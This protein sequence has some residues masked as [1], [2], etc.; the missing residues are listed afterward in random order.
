M[1]SGAGIWHKR[2]VSPTAVPLAILVGGLLFTLAIASVVMA[3]GRERDE[4]RFERAVLGT[5]DLI[6]RRLDLYLV[7]LRGTA[8]LFA[9]LDT[10]RPED[11]RAYVARLDV[12]HHYPGIQG[13]GWTQRLEAGLDEEGEFTER[14]AIR[15]LEPLDARNQA[16]LGYD[17]YSEP[18]RRAAMSQARDRATAALSGR[19]RLVQEIY[20][21]EQPGFLLYVPV[22]RGGEPPA[23]LEQRRASLLGFVYSPFRARDLFEGI[24]GF[25]P[26]PR[27]SFRVYDGPMADAGQLLY[28]SARAPGHRPAQSAVHTLSQSGRQ[29][30]VTFESTPDFEAGSMGIAPW[31][32]ILAGLAT[33]L[34]L[35]FLAR[36]QGRARAEAERANQAK[37]TFLAT[38][39]HELR[40]PLNAIA[41]YVDLLVLEVPGALTPKQR[42]FL[43]RIAS[44]QQH[45]LT[46]IDD[47]L[48][49]A[50]LEAGRTPIRIES[51]D[52]H[53]LVE[54]AEP[55]VEADLAANGIV[56][57]MAGGPPATVLADPEKARQ[58]LVNLLAN[59][60]KFTDSGGQVTLS[61]TTDEHTVRIHV[62]DTGIGIPRSR[63]ASI[64]NPFTQVEADL[65]RTRHGTGLGLSISR[66]LA[67]VMKG[68]ILVGSAPGQGSTFT[69][70]LPGRGDRQS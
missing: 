2:V 7:T 15:Y 25:D 6:D 63:L 62:K 51:V 20:G 14:H 29:W 22:Y 19:V 16:A 40:T 32:V 67:R 23:D 39:S 3:V 30:T 57:E 27:V 64:F 65:T 38:M 66:Q 5:R 45:L 35:F 34:W 4:A 11:F 59:A 43:D 42:Q 56:Y 68:D 44:A 46:L 52:V 18:T 47:I 49:F 48:N 54:T 31:A 69:L 8:G 24:L 28:E 13:V 10:V 41:G 37:S 58:I 12:Q 60:A 17:M 9:A 70:V 36:G 53:T 55:L 26:S 50:K 1:A 33:S 21:P 61:W